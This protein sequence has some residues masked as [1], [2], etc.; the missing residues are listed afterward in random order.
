MD[1]ADDKRMRIIACV[2]PEP[3]RVRHVW[4]RWTDNIWHMFAVRI[5]VV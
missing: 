4:Q 3:I 2:T 5:A 1:T